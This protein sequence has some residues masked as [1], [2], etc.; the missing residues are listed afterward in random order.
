MRIFGPEMKKVLI[1]GL[2]ILFFWSSLLY[3]QDTARTAS[4]LPKGNLYPTIRL[5]YKESQISCS[6]YALYAADRWQ[7]RAF[8][9]F[10]LGLRSNIIRWEHD[11][12]RVSELGFELAVFTQF[13]FED[14]FGEF[15][16]S[17][18]NNEY[19]LGIHYQYQMNHWRLRGR[20]YHIS[21]HLGDDYIF[22]NGIEGFIDN[23]RIYEVVDLSAAWVK[24][25]WQLYGI[26]GLFIHSAYPREP[27]MFQTG[28]QF[29][30]PIGEKDCLR[31]IAGTDLRFEQEQDF[32]PGFRIG[33]GIGI[34]KKGKFPVTI[35]ADYYNGYLPYSLYDK[36]L[37]QWIGASLFF[38]PF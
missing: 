23:T 6:L 32:R 19:K 38:N 17:L 9:V 8:G 5:D 20:I 37:I 24:G 34:G 7:N 11:P 18:F 1:S 22:R 3:C 16:T 27:L 35:I 28:V 4:W 31:W 26:A 13:I 10:S 33:G 14:L 15:Q 30:H 29:E 2:F 36:V 12:Q 21:A 25:W